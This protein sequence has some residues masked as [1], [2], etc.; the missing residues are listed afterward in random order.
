MTKKELYEKAFVILN[1]REQRAYRELDQR[2]EEIHRTIPEIE[3][4]QRS[5]SQVSIRLSKQILSHQENVSEGTA[6]IL[7]EGMRNNQRIE[8]LLVSHG[9]PANYLKPHFVCSK[10]RDTGYV[11]G[12]LCSCV[13][14]VV[15]KLGA[16]ELNE[17]TTMQLCTFDD[18]DL[19][20]YRSAAHPEYLLKM[21]E[22]LDFC[23][24]YAKSFKK[25]SQSILMI[26]P[27]GLGKTHLSLA[28][29]S[30]VL[31]A[32]YQ[33]VYG[34]APDFFRRIQNEYFGKNKE[35]SD[36]QNKLLEADLLIFD[37]LGAEFEN[38]M[39]ASIL[40]SI[41]NGRLNLGKP[42]IINT[43]LTIGELER[44][45]TNRMVSRLTTLY[46]PLRF[47]G[48]DIRQLKLQES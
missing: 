26:G 18:F 47:V 9:Y 40:Y 44:R 10:C 29:A 48:T 12:E 20:Y 6:K 28:I 27:T 21:K 39:Y 45:Y 8:Q 37:D 19:R 46:T 24:N 23:K 22:N 36:T 11:H 15:R 14:E 33:V 35:T 2:K 31:D 38:G 32:G 13:Q 17:S 1:Q 3:F 4:L 41:V 7:E 5:L 43:N 34:S 42:T 25:T 16:E 30:V